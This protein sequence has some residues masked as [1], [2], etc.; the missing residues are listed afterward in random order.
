MGCEMPIFLENITKTYTN[1]VNKE[2]IQA[3][4]SIDLK[5]ET[6]EFIS[7]LGPSGC[8][9]SSLL[10]IIAGLTEP[11]TGT[12][13]F[14]LDDGLDSKAVV[15]QSYAL[16]PWMTV[17]GNLQ[18]ALK[19]QKIDK[20]KWTEL[21]SHYLDLVGLKEFMD[22]YPNQLSGGMKQR[23]AIARALIANPSILLFDEP[24]GAL[25]AITRKQLN[26]MLLDLIQATEKTVVLITHSI[27]EALQLSN[28]IV[29][30]SNRPGR[31]LKIYNV[32]GS[33]ISRSLESRYINDIYNEIWSQLE[34]LI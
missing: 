9:K 20:S 16:F 31:I 30:F 10:E 32:P 13:Y 6:G 11:T 34:S 7:F 22:H 1:N 17:R 14:D 26:N 27:E 21:C 4:L 19:T 15:F 29:L 33:P 12:V 8:G 23:V 24:F 2:S 3:L 18:F 25:D 5:I 28:R